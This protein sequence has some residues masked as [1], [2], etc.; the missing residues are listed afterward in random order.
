MWK[1]EAGV[2]RDLKLLL[3]PGKCKGF[4]KLLSPNGN[5]PG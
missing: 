1:S 3:H 4:N 5:N 2:I